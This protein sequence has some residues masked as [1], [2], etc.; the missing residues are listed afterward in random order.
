MDL[1][2]CPKRDLEQ[3]H[4]VKTTYQWPQ[5]GLRADATKRAHIS[6]MTQTR[7]IQSIA[8]AHALARSGGITP[9]TGVQCMQE[10]CLPINKW[11]ISST[12]TP[13]GSLQTATSPIA[14]TAAAFLTVSHSTAKENG[15][16]L[17]TIMR[18]DKKTSRSTLS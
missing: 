18:K 16:N 15:M 11:S 13:L 6:S 8:A 5:G 9:S 12:P 3:K 7:H 14:A 17:R 1:T 2:A 10:L 4:P